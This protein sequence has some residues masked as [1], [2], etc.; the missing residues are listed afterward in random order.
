MTRRTP[1]PYLAKRQQNY[2]VINASFDL[3]VQCLY[4][5]QGNYDALIIST[6]SPPSNAQ[7]S[8]WFISFLSAV[9]SCVIHSQANNITNLVIDVRSN[10]GKLFLGSELPKEV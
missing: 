9:L 8:N 6:F 5:A 2:E 4:F 7:F 1:I 3:S 10:G